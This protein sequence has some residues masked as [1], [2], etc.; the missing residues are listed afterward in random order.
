MQWE[1]WCEVIEV[2]EACVKRSDLFVNW[3]LDSDKFSSK[4]LSH[5]YGID[6]SVMYLD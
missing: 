5:G 1:K 4:Y 2:R 3:E 6:I